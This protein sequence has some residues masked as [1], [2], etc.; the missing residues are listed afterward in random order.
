MLPLARGVT[1]AEVQAFARQLYRRG[2][3]SRRWPSAMWAPPKPRPRCAAWP[4]CWAPRACPT[5]SCC[6][7]A[8]WWPA[9]AGD[10]HQ[11]AAQGQQLGLAWRAGAGRRQRR[12]ARRHTAD[13]RR[14]QRPVLQRAAHTPA[15]G[16]HRAER[17]LSR[18]NGRRW[19]CSSCSRAST[20]PTCWKHAPMPSSAP[21]PRSC[22]TARRGL[23]HAGGWR[24]IAPARARQGHRRAR[25]APVCAGLRQ[26]RRLVDAP[27]PRWPRWTP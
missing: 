12:D 2:Q 4:R 21:C 6:A 15:A 19:P 3:S 11:P 16:L 1:L 9:G 26:E 7:T 23:G 14:D 20:A 25:A 22:R 10:P 8:S 18:T 17:H 27:K 5:H 24:A 13:R